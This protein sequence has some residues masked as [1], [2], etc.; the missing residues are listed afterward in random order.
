[1]I[2]WSRGSDF[3]T[4]IASNNENNNKLKKGLFIF[5]KL[6]I[7]YTRGDYLE[8]KLSTFVEND[9]A[10]N[11]FK[12]LSQ[13][14]RI[15][16]T[17]L[18]SSYQNILG[19][20]DILFITKKVKLSLE[21]VTKVKN[22]IEQNSITIIFINE[23][24]CGTL[25]LM[26][27]LNYL[28]NNS[29]SKNNNDSIYQL[30][31]DSFTKLAKRSLT[32][33]NF[34]SKYFNVTNKEEYLNVDLEDKYLNSI[35]PSNITNINDWHLLLKKKDNYS[36]LLHKQHKVLISHWRGSYLFSNPLSEDLFDCLVKHLLFQNESDDRGTLFKKVVG[37]KYEKLIDLTILCNDI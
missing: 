25:N 28:Q 27:Q 32:I 26:C 17:L 6:E 24:E 21:M 36:I 19:N 35:H 8:R 33:N 22:L 4:V 31:T 2:R 18:E 3:K 23:K 16:C 34:Y 37:G 15:E 12:L 11:G 9:E 1:M 5:S 14:D 7:L 10:N 29:I 13:L 20:Y 30:N